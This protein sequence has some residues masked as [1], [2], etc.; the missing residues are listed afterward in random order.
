MKKDLK[1]KLSLNKETISSLD[2][3]TLKAA[4][5]GI[6]SL[7]PDNCVSAVD[8]MCV[9]HCHEHTCHRIICDFSMVCPTI[10]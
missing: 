1:K 10:P 6:V 5:G 7:V 2:T 8:T 3:A 4:K 9:T